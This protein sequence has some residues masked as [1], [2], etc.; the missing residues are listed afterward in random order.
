VRTFALLGL[1][2]RAIDFRGS[3]WQFPGGRIGWIRWH[4]PND[5][6]PVTNAAY[7]DDDPTD[8]EANRED[9]APSCGRF[10]I[11]AD[12]EEPDAAELAAAVADGIAALISAHS[13]FPVELSITPALEP[14]WVADGVVDLMIL[15]ARDD[16]L[17]PFGIGQ[18]GKE[19]AVFEPAL[20]RRAVEWIEPMLREPNWRTVG[21]FAAVIY[22]QLSA[23]DLFFGP[24]EV[25]YVIEDRAAYAVSPYAAAVAERAFHAAYK[26]L[27]AIIGGKAP[28]DD[29]RLEKRL[30][31]AGVDPHRIV[32]IPDERGDA[33][34]R[35]FRRL[36][37]VRNK[38]AAHGGNTGVDRGLHYYDVMEAQWVL[39]DA[40]GEAVDA[41][42][43]AGA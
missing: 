15:E 16:H 39:S 1:G 19:V 3:T 12:G 38:H 34:L 37:D 17:V 31:K 18:R 22:H 29:S 33:M 43:R 35:R 41:R 26:G 36:E 25:R 27:E 24:D 23:S 14:A 7:P 42:L 5:E 2:A 30:Q 6:Y 21:P 20:H 9:Y 28:G 4:D 11:T 32:A 8:V 40:I 13:P 10:T